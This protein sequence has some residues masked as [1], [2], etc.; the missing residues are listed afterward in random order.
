MNTA[1]ASDFNYESFDRQMAE[2]LSM[3]Y[4]LVGEWDDCTRE[5]M[6]FDL[7]SLCVKGSRLCYLIDID[8]GLQ[9]EDL[10]QSRREMNQNYYLELNE[11]IKHV[12]ELMYR[13]IEEMRQKKGLH[14]PGAKELQMDFGMLMPKLEEW[15][16]PD[17]EGND[18][19]LETFKVLPLLFKEVEKSL[20]VIESPQEPWEMSLLNLFKY[21]ASLC[22]L[23][24]H[25]QSLSQMT[26]EE[27]NNEEAGR[28]LTG[29]VLAY[30][31]TD[32]GKED[33]RNFIAVLK[34][35]HDGR[36]PDFDDLSM[37]RRRLIKEVPRAFQTCFMEHINDISELA[38]S[39]VTIR[40]LPNDEDI[41][42]LLSAISKYQW[43]SEQMYEYSHPE[44]I[45]PEL[46][47]KVFY[48]SINGKPIDFKYLRRKIEKMLNLIN[49]KNHWFCIYSVL[50]Y[51]HYIKDPVATH[52]AEQMQHRDWFP[53]LPA[54]LQ[55]SG[56]TLTE[57]NGY[58]NENTFPT[59]NR[60]RYDS[61][62]LLNRKK[63]WSP[64]LWSKF[65]RLCY[66]LD[67]VF[68]VTI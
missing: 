62:R 55:F 23:L 15:M 61:F 48:T 56:E 29:Q 24:F 7:N 41:E 40:P 65:Q 49:K 47:N 59:W 46:Y 68:K 11:V 63:K 36:M 52:F 4:L 17:K 19:S 38:M 5:E 34:Y 3:S 32:K 26:D 64:D 1:T 35:E 25:F 44:S 18:A 9:K 43:L 20:D 12:S 28:M 22:L 60:E 21:F 10:T 8:L 53:N 42:A 57:Y 50:K 13:A 27:V 51:N 67:E 31:E 30:L 2:F 66:D 37:E 58:L 14:R 6:M 54:S 45:E 39:I 16:L 33:L